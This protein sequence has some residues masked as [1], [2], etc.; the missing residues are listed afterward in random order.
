MHSNKLYFYKARSEFSST[1]DLVMLTAAVNIYL[2]EN[3]FPFRFGMSSV[4][5]G[6]SSDICAEG[7]FFS[8]LPIDRLRNFL[9][10]LVNN[11]PL[12]EDRHRVVQTLDYRDEYDGRIH[13][14]DTEESDI[15]RCR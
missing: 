1:I 15:D 4:K 13:Q 11:H 2:I 12:A 8:S 3:N 14:W 7:E 9:W 5:E 6:E 10:R